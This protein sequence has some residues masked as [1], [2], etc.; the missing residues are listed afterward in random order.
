MEKIVV[1]L[2]PTSTGK[3]DLALHLAKKFNGEIVSCDSRQ[4]Y[5]RLDIGTG[6][7]PSNLLPF[8]D[9]KVKA[10]D[11]GTGKMPEKGTNVKKGEGWWEIDDVR[12]WMY[13]VENPKK[14]YT[15][16]DYVKDAKKV[17]EDVRK[18]GK[19]P[20]IVGGTGLYLKA[21]LYGLSN[22]S[23]SV[24]WKIRGELELLNLNKLQEKL[25]QLSINKW[26]S[27]N[28][29]DSQNPRRL[30]RAI[31]LQ[32]GKTGKS[33]TAVKGL[34]KEFKILKIG[35]TASREILYQRSDERV[36][37]RIKQGMIEEAQRLHKHGLS[38]DRMR[39]LGLEYGILADFIEEKVKTQEELIKILQGKIHGYIRRQ[40]TWF[41][42]EIEVVWFNIE[43]K[44]FL[45]KVENIV[46]K[47][48][49][50]S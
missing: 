12:I 31:E 50:P 42:R 1:I 41:K 15:V 8:A 23:I 40:L 20:I 22:L 38:L 7:L 28:P 27:L 25:K 13:D 18:R 14:Q 9:A 45:K 26:N 29:S 46:A 17:I 33:S 24:D 47:W 21:L 4:V 3:T 30:V 5:K 49:Y 44:D 37:N 32:L 6:K 35:L 34:V 11:I 16:A 2:G 48:Y 36:L 39:Q 10:L 19:L 43:N